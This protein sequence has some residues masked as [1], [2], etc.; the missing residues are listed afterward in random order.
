MS[1]PRAT[2]EETLPY[3]PQDRKTDIKHGRRDGRKQIP[4]YRTL[5]ALVENAERIT[6]PYQE[7]LINSCLVRVDEEYESFLRRVARWRHQLSE[8]GGQLAADEEAA[9][10]AAEQV[11]AAQAE[12]TEAELLPRNPQELA[13]GDE[14]ALWAR[15]ETMRQRRIAAARDAHELL[16]TTIDTRRREMTELRGR[17]D[18]EF[19]VA[20][21]AARRLGDYFVLR[22]AA[23]WDALAQ[24]H[25][26]GRHLASLVPVV[27]PKLPA[28]V[29]A[30]RQDGIITGP[31]PAGD[32]GGRDGATG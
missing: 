8:L 11:V 21:A 5:V 13:L 25:P 18:H 20:Q 14:T 24:S 1:R 22:V 16:L 28:W 29:D 31:P 27:V 23:Y 30:T 7:Q 3:S 17:I 6:T 2:A 12:L 19:T 26:E 15:R 4:T 10:R 32:G 9:R